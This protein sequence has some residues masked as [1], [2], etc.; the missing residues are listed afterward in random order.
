MTDT[1]I[2]SEGE[3]QECLRLEKSGEILAKGYH[4]LDA[5][6][7]ELRESL[8]VCIDELMY[9]ST[10]GQLWMWARGNEAVPERLLK[11]RE[12]LEG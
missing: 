4:R 10:T 6:N 1:N 5:E 8:K 9:T 12:L 11:I 3:C 2:Q 7:K